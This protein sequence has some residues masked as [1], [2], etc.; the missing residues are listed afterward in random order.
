[1][2]TFALTF[3]FQLFTVA[4]R[5]ITEDELN[6]SSVRLSLI[7]FYF[8]FLNRNAVGTSILGHLL[9]TNLV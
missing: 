6:F 7:S 1:M 5:L 9:V 4:Q 8:L 3:C 2:S